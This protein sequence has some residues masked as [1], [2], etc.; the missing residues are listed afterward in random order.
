MLRISRASREY[1]FF[2]LA[3][4]EQTEGATV[5]VAFVPVSDAG[6]YPRPGNEDRKAATWGEDPEGNP[7]VQI[8]IGPGTDLPLTPGLYRAILRI[9]T[10]AEQIERD[11]DYIEILA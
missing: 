7:S 11:L 6:T 10:G 9:T 1:V 2:P 3:Q 8:R 5:S 4:D